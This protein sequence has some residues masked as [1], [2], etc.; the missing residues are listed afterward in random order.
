MSGLFTKLKIDDNG[1]KVTEKLAGYAQ[2]NLHG[3]I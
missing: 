3:H 2:P 1:I